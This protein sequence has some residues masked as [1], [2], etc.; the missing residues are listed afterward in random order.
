MNPYNQL[1]KIAGVFSHRATLTKNDGRALNM[2]VKPE[3]KASENLNA[4]VPSALVVRE[5]SCNA[6]S[7]IVGDEIFYPAAGDVLTVFSDDGSS[8]RYDC[9]R[10]ATSGRYWDWRYLR[11]GYRVKFYTKYNPKET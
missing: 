1:S 9:A 3:T 6:E 7:F 11:P 8:L 10:D 4:T 5:W 2:Y